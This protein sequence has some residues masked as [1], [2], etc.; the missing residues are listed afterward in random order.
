[1]RLKYASMKWSHHNPGSPRVVL[2]A[3]GCVTA[4][5][6]RRLVRGLLCLTRAKPTEAPDV[7]CKPVEVKVSPLLRSRK[8][9]SQAAHHFD[10]IAEP[11]AAKTAASCHK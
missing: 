10:H 5:V 8:P 7:S 11:V 4:R 2:Q 3:S 6:N 1:M 9:A